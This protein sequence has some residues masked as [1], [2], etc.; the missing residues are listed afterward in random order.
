MWVNTGGLLLNGDALYSYY[1][2][3]YSYFIHI[4]YKLQLAAPNSFFFCQHLS[5][6]Y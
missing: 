3:V 4:S 1:Q 2:Y 5:R 6:D